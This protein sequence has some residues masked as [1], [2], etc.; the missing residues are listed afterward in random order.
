MRPKD[1]PA[2]LW[3]I[4]P[5]IQ[6]EEFL[7]ERSKNKGKS[8]GG[9]GKSS[10]SAGKSSEDQSKLASNRS[11]SEQPRQKTQILSIAEDDDDPSGRWRQ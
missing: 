1:V 7:K 4:T 5:K 11:Q 10:G 8:S 3:I 2:D 6:K 9:S